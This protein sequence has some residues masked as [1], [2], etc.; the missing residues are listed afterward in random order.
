[1]TATLPPDAVFFNA[2]VL[3]IDRRT[4]R[5][6]ALAVLHGRIVAL[7]RSRD[8][9]ALAGRAT[10][11]HD[12]HGATVIPGF[13]DAHC[14]VLSYGFSLLHVNLG[15]AAR[16]ADIVHAVARRAARTP[17]GHWI[18]GRG[19]NDNKLAELRHPTRRDIDPVSEGRP[20]WLQHTSGH[21][22]VANSQAL[23]RAGIGRDTPDPEGGVIDRDPTGE[24]TGLLKE[25]AQRLV[26]RAIP[27]ASVD[28]AKAALAAAGKRFVAEGLTS[29]QDARSG[30]LVPDE[31]RAYQ[32]ATD[33]G[34]LPTRTSLLLDVEALPIVDGRLAF[35]LGLTSGFGGDRLRL[36]GIK[37]FLDGSLIGRTAAMTAPY[38]SDPDTRGFLL[39]S[40]EKLRLQI[41]ASSRA[42]WQVGMHAIGDRAI[43]VAIAAADAAL[44]AHVKAR[45]PRIEH[46][47]VLRPDLIDAIGQRGM[48]IVT[49]PRFITELGDGFRRALGEERLRLCYPLRSLRGCRV[50]FS[51]DRPVVEGAPLGGIEAAV[52]ERTGSGAAYVPA[53]RISVLEAIRWY[54]E[55]AAYAQFQEHALGTLVPGKWAD[56][57]ALE[58][59]PTTVSPHELSKIRVVLTAV[60]GEVAYRA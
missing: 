30:S 7:G 46:C 5:T 32:E 57:C 8:I 41:E 10:R 59:D 17:G 33:E 36:G 23:E 43:E 22:G 9:K 34:R 28:D 24:P 35:G 3:T 51:S 27:A 55:G 6:E 21:M 4:P 45:R 60:G 19:Y 58:S 26:A 1:V 29:V 54:T 13:N 11:R 31:L 56:L 44:G 47:G 53:E 49:Q 16:I 38:A 48:V 40:E 18:L 12:L 2:N 52:T 20:V 42:G 14:H 37:I 15:S 39:K 50:A 25:T